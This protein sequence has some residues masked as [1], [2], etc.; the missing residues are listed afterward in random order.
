MPPIYALSPRI[1]GRLAQAPYNSHSAFGAS[2][3]LFQEIFSVHLL[4][5]HHPLHV[6]RDQVELEIHFG[7]PGKHMEVRDFPGVRDDPDGEAFLFNLSDGE[8]DP[9]DCN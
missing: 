7:P 6:F 5:L 1:V 9:I 8:A 3:F 2:S 4:L